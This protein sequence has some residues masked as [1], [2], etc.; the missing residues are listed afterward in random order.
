VD[1]SNGPGGAHIT[2]RDDTSSGPY[3]IPLRQMSA[4]E[5]KGIPADEGPWVFKMGIGR[6]EITGNVLIALHC[7]HINLYC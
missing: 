5:L 1:A 4:D 2:R 6:T 3:I 7:Q